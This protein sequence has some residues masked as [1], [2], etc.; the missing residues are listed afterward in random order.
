MPEGC[1]SGAVFPFRIQ[2]HQCSSAVTRR[3]WWLHVFVA[4]EDI[5]VTL[6]EG[7]EVYR[8]TIGS[9]GL[10]TILGGQPCTLVPVAL[11]DRHPPFTITSTSTHS[12]EKAGLTA[13]GST[14]AARRGVEVT[15]GSS[16]R[17]AKR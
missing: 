11:V 17:R 5:R 4:I 15:R 9:S 16:P 10:T 7:P 12:L 8:K 1:G 6:N 2:W 14:A 13:G 3:V